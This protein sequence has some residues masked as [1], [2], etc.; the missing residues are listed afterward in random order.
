[1]DR[2]WSAAPADN[3]LAMA[4]CVTSGAF[5]S[6]DRAAQVL[7]RRPDCP[8]QVAHYIHRRIGTQGALA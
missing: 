5:P 8:P 7:T 2:C 6:A 3:K 1:M 4:E